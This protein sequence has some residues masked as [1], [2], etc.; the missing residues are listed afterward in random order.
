MG[1][2]SGID[3]QHEHYSKHARTMLIKLYICLLR[4]VSIERM[5]YDETDAM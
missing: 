5:T 4:L 2:G 1:M 3:E